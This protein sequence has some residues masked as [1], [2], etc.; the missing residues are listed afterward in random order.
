LAGREEPHGGS[1]LPVDDAAVTDQATRFG[2]ILARI[3]EW[4]AVHAA[5][6]VVGPGGILAAHGDPT[7]RYPWASVTKLVTA[8]TVLIA[9]ERGHFSLDDAAGPP[10]AT[11]R[12][13]L[14]HASGLPFRGGAI[15]APP[16][17][18]RIYSNRAFDALGVLV[19]DRAGRPFDAV[20]TDLVLEPL[21]MD[22]T[23]LMERPS[24]GLHGPLVDLAAFAREMLRPT[25]ID[26]S[27][28]AA[29]TAVAFPGLAGVVPG[30]GRFDPCDWG[31]GF[32]L[33]DGKTAHWMGQRNSPSAFGHFGGSGTFV[34]LD[35]EAHIGLAV[36]TDR[37][38]GLWA[39][40]AWPRFSDQVLSAASS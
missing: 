38:F 14:A 6:A 35:P 23:T 18:R 31:L 29:A 28:L 39:L 25:L 27:T 11:I 12:H 2:P 3:D 16:G 37:A 10:G 22:G 1:L 26:G 32:E 30:V 21:G 9:V 13:L 4:G 8:L 24:Q 15:V 40:D 17:R 20:L 33:H 19:S 34:W 5:A 36:L 7:R